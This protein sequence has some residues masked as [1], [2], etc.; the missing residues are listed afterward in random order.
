MT[1]ILNL[2]KES[3]DFV[4]NETVKTLKNGGLI[5]FP[6]D[7]VYGLLVD[8]TQERAVDK[9][10]AFKN[11]PPGKAISVFV[12]DM[13]MIEKYSTLSEKQQSL[14]ETILPGPFTVVLP[15]KHILVPALESETGTLGIRIP[16]FAP[17]NEL[18]EK[19]RSPVTATSANLGGS[20]PH[21]SIE[22][23]LHQ[24]PKKKEELI[25]L[26]VDAGKLPRNKPSTVVDLTGDETKTLREGE[27]LFDKK[28]LYLSKSPEQTQKIG[29]FIIDKTMK[30]ASGKPV[31]IILK[32]DLGTGKTEMSRG[33][34]RFLGIE[35]VVSPTFVVYY[36]Y[37]IPEGNKLK[38]ERFVHAD[39]YNITDPQEFENLSLEDYV[40]KPSIMVV[41]WGEK[42][43][44][45]Y[46]TFKQK[47]QVIFVEIRHKSE[48]EREIEI[49]E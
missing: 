28:D 13:E 9:L 43:G 17:V 41:E 8:S 5:V 21:Y 11:R 49:K 37:D 24:L 47:A 38:Y 3:K 15:S 31:V 42:L 18:I 40:D 36:E 34:A 45:L 26:I 33:I 25:D 29:E 14:L 48:T 32:G 12:R 19:Y 35:K 22:S 27:I 10:I 44:K 6:S 16:D 23:F 46:E 4:I 7:T 30:K 1:R 2:T 20:N 39:L